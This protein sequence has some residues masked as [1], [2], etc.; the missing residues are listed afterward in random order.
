MT[1]AIQEA[2]LRGKVEILPLANVQPNGWNP[3]IVPEH[4]MD[5]IRHGFRAD[6][7]LVSQAL[8]VW[9]TDDQG[10]ERNVI[11]DGEHRWRAGVDVGLD[12]GP[13]VRL[14]GLSEIEAKA[15]TV[16]LNQKRGAWD[17]EALAALVAEISPALIEAGTDLAVDLGFSSGEVNALI[18][19]GTGAADPSVTGPREL[20]EGAIGQEVASKK[21]LIV[22]ECASREQAVSVAE[23]CASQGWTFREEFA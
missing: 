22:V 5:S 11:I 18:A 8:L 20:D 2:K 6:G 21:L 13:M 9:A 1:E 3:N 14:K 19:L 16:K 4:V 7:W 15:L 10:A 12:K 23:H 17:T